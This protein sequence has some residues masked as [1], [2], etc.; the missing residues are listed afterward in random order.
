MHH[1]DTSMGVGGDEDR[2]LWKKKRGISLALLKKLL[3]LIDSMFNSSGSHDTYMMLFINLSPRPPISVVHCSF[4]PF[5]INW[6]LY[7]LSKII[8]R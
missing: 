6:F 4:S 3:K 1:P 2:M 5:T 7:V 8:S